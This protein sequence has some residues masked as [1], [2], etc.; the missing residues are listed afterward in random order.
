MAVAD[1]SIRCI[2][3]IFIQFAGPKL[4]PKIF[5]GIRQALKPG[6]WAFVQGYRPE[7]LNYRTGGPD[8]VDNL[9]TRELL[10]K[11]FEDFSS[12]EIAEYDSEIHEGHGHGGMSALIDLVGCK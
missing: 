12:I 1:R 9:Y 2:A 10:E 11:S 5:A 3:A 6:G 4:R 8:K 7:Q